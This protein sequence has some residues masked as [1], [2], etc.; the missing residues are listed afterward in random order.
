VS[1]RLSLAGALGMALAALAGATAPASRAADECQGLQ[2]CIPVAGP[3]VVI[4]GA[5]PK[6]V[7]WQLTCPEG[8]VAGVDARV[9]DQGT[10]VTFDGLVGSPV[11]P[12]RTTRNTLLFTARATAPTKAPTSFQ[13]FIGCV[14]ASGGS[15]T[16]TAFRPGSPTVLRVLTLRVAAGGVARGAQGCHADERLLQAGVAVGLRTTVEPTP[17]Q[18]AGVRLAADV[19]GGKVV[20]AAERRA[21]ID[22]AIAVEVQLQALCTR[23]R[24]P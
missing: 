2:V 17:G 10:D 19:R 21:A 4:P 8:I 7:Q 20:A 12:G 23:G 9:A 11:G 13:P 15:R 24:T 16:P 18:L 14:P 5:A 3:W 6:L 22:P 1:T